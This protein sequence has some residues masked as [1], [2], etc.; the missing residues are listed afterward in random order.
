MSQSSRLKVN[1]FLTTHVNPSITNPF[2]TRFLMANQK[3]L[4]RDESDSAAVQFDLPF[5]NNFG[6]NYRVIAFAKEPLSG[7]LCSSSSWRPFIP[8]RW[9]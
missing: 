8:R 4:F 5:Y 6:D 3:Q 2:Y 9:I 7:R 1:I